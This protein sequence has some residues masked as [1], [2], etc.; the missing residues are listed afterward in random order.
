MAEP[1]PPVEF[2]AEETEADEEPQPTGPERRCIVTGQV[3]P[4]EGLL[5]FV[6]GPSGE[7]VPDLARV[8]PGRGIWLSPARDV[9]NT[10]VTKRLFAKAARRAV[11]VDAGLADRL[12]ALLMRR[13]L[14]IIGMARRAGAAVCGFEKVKAEIKARKAALLVEARDA[15]A[16]GRGK[17]TAL[18]AGLPTVELFDA[19]E[20]GWVFGRDH[21]VH[22]C[23]APG[24]LAE[25]LMTEARLLAGFRL[26]PAGPP[27][28]A[29]K[30]TKSIT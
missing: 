9:V 13:C 1:A 8:L 19:A 14:D 7:V 4:K 6:V 5:R 28:L 15:A 21:A 10:A 22:V 23:L 17:M 25:R 24:R 29:A 16:D 27:A 3:R 12:E 11:T 2:E 18:A 30:E 26:P 20:L